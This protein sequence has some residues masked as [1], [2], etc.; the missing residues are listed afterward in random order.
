MKKTTFKIDKMDCPCEENLIRLKLE[1]VESIANQE[2][3]LNNR[4]LSIYHSGDALVIEEAINE[5]NLGSKLIESRNVDIDSHSFEQDENQKQRRVLLIVLAINFIFFLLEMST[6]I[7]S[8][9]MGLVADS[10]DMLADAFVYGLSLFAVGAAVSRKKRV[11][12]ICGYFQILLALLGFI[13]V[14]KRFIGVEELPDFR[15]MIGISILALIANGVCLIL[16]QRTKSED[17]HIQA[18]LI[19]SSNDV[20]INAGV[21]IAG[22]LV[23]ILENGIPDLI[24]G[25]IVF[26]IVIRGA[27][28]ILKLSK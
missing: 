9:S 17:A 2:Y 18:S 6:G 13:E 21:I 15:L 14:V 8:Q 7:L 12:M 3:D 27:L 16:L 26:L 5:L 11:A 23:L 25:S 10:L 1:S 19:F 4:L 22:L 24:I 20:I 28:R